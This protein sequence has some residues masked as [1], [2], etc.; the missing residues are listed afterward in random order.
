MAPAGSQQELSVSPMGMVTRQTFHFALVVQGQIPFELCLGLATSRMTV[1]AIGHLIFVAVNA[2]L[3][4]VPD[5]DPFVSRSVG[6][7]AVGAMAIGERLMLH[8][9]RH[10]IDGGMTE[11]TKYRNRCPQV[12]FEF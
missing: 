12:V 1:F 6:I 2:K 4:R 8:G 3:T 7:V 10:V 9:I 11:E 5:Q